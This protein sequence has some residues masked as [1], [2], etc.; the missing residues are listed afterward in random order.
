MHHFFLPPTSIQ[1]SLVT[2]P[3]EIARQIQAVLRL[4]AGQ[5]VLVLDNLG[6]EFEVEL[7][8]VERGGVSG[9]VMAQRLAGGEPPVQLALYLCLAQREK[10][11]WMLQKCTEVGACEFIPV[12]S[13]RSLVQE[14]VEGKQERWERILREAAEQSHRGR[15]PVLRPALRYEAA[16]AEAAR[17]P[18]RL[19]PWEQEDT[20]DLRTALR[21][22]GGITGIR[23]TSAAVLIGP[24]G[25]FSEAE[26]AAARAAGF[27][28]ITLG[29]RILRMETAAVV[30]AALVLHE[31]S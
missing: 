8:E 6:S 16:L 17:H 18:M 28:P 22:T 14:R 2:F 26:V 1:G 7:S 30:A 4:R 5:R 27:L 21:P 9:S 3:S 11:E 24:E 23:P 12:I 15:V 13:S 10:F 31:L 19:I 25:G 29:P 20:L